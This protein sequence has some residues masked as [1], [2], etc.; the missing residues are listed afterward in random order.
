MDVPLKIKNLLEE[1]KKLHEL[2]S[3]LTAELV[4]LKTELRDR[5]TH[6][7]QL[8]DEIKAQKEEISVIEKDFNIIKAESD[9]ANKKL[10]L[11]EIPFKS[12]QKQIQT[13]LEIAIGETNKTIHKIINQNLSTNEMIAKRSELFSSIEETKSELNDATNELEGKQLAYNISFLLEDY[14]KLLEN[15]LE[16]RVERILPLID[17]KIK[18]YKPSHGGKDPISD[19][20]EKLIT[21]IYKNILNSLKDLYEIYQDKIEEIGI[22]K[23]K[24]SLIPTEIE[25]LENKSISFA[26]KISLLENE[27]KSSEKEAKENEI[28]IDKLNQSIEN[29]KED[30]NR[31]QSEFNRAEHNLNFINKNL[32]EN[33]KELNSSQKAK[34][35]ALENFPPNIPKTH[36][37]LIEESQKLMESLEKEI[38]EKLSTRD[39]LFTQQAAHITEYY[40]TVQDNGNGKNV[41]YLNDQK[42]PILNLRKG[43]TYKFFIDKDTLDNHPFN[44][45][46]S[47][48]EENLLTDTDIE[49]VFEYT[50]PENSPMDSLVYYCSK[51]LGMGGKIEIKEPYST[52]IEE[53][54]TQIREVESKAE[55]QF[56]ISDKLQRELKDV[57]DITKEFDKEITEF[58]KKIDEIKEEKEKEEKI[59]TKTSLFIDRYE[60]RLK[61]F[62]TAKEDLTKKEE[63]NKK[64]YENLEKSLSNTKSSF[65]EKITQINELED[66]LR[67][68]REEK[69]NGNFEEMVN[70]STKLLENYEST[71]EQF[72]TQTK[73]SALSDLNESQKAK[74]EMEIS[75][76]ETIEELNEIQ[77]VLIPFDKQE[78]T[79]QIIK[80]EIQ[81]LVTSENAD[82]KAFLDGIQSQGKELGNLTAEQAYTDTLVTNFSM[83]KV[84][85]EIQIAINSGKTSTTLNGNLSPFT[86]QALFNNGFKLSIDG[87]PPRMVIDWSNPD[88]NNTEGN[89]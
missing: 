23:N 75:I 27:I 6:R 29:L 85:E 51:H 78:T 67:E 30:Y 46:I 74:E 56:D 20:V 26:S 61:N 19:E 47:Q 12:F 68:L 81:N 52:Q 64:R 24:L 43:F 63:E 41:Y 17:K 13:S 22:F 38:E 37:L 69:D 62:E 8:S 5:E 70:E 66:Q 57:M 25:K 83:Q 60:E 39:S 40:I 58:I 79:T 45:S 87:N 1:L 28:N 2:E 65:E 86:A 89:K 10:N 14:I 34:E 80:K 32:E 76:K 84:K 4:D 48:G 82:S 71:K 73:G 3:N 54:V 88:Y 33:E 35:E 77:K 16:F 9:A 50:I 55:E 11:A 18:N 59:I 72:I 21:D 15:N 31:N 44:V 42:Q 36:P 49:G 7:E 53:I